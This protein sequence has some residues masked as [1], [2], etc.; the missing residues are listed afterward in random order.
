MDI[1]KLIEAYDTYFGDEPVDPNKLTDEQIDEIIGLETDLWKAI[2][3]LIIA[4]KLF[5]N[6]RQIV[7]KKEKIA[8]KIIARILKRLGEHSWE[9]EDG[10]ALF[11]PSYVFDVDMT[12]LPKDY[13]SSNRSKINWALARGESIEGVTVTDSHWYVRV[14]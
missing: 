9:N 13:V 4:K 5:A 14:Y 11:C 12:T 1:T 7:E 8:T 3:S 10:K 2:N 6:R